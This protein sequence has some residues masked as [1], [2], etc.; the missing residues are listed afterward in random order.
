MGL[1]ALLSHPSPEVRE[2]WQKPS[3][4]ELGSISQG[5]GE[6]EGKDACFFIHKNE[7]PRDEK[8]TYPRAAAGY[9]PE[10]AGS[11]WVLAR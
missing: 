2:R 7:V 9:R 10:K 8:A 11:P 3:A 1:Q 5:F 4:K 6:A